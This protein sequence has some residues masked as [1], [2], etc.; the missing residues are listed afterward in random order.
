MSIMPQGIRFTK[1]QG[2]GNDFIVISS[3]ALP[4]GV[5]ELAERLCDRHFGVGADGLVYILPSEKGDFR[6]RILNRD[7]S[8]AEQCGNAVRCVAKYYYER[9]SNAKK[10]LLIETQA[11]LQRVWVEADG[12]T[13]R[14]VCVDMGKPILKGER[15]PVKVNESQVVAHPIEVE[16]ETFHFTAVSMGNPHAVIFVDDAARFP[17]KTWGLRLESHPLF[18]NRVNVEIVTVTSRE[19]LQMRVWERGVG[20]TLACGTGACASVVAAVLN[21]KTGRR[22]LVRLKGGDLEIEWKENDQRIYMTGVAENV[23]EGEW[24]RSF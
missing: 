22:V 7:G 20:E 15:I 1:M 18:P 5:K 21:G 14:R 12:Q 19:E 3:Q 11:G 24:I 6:M 13:V 10:E 8:E 23:F 17:L 9:I 16:G 2:L 4:D